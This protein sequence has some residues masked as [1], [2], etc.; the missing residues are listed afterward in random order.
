MQCYKAFIFKIM[1]KIKQKYL[2]FKTAERNFNNRKIAL[3]DEMTKEMYISAK[4][5]NIERFKTI[6][7][8]MISMLGE[9]YRFTMIQI[10]VL[11]GLNA[12]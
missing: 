3:K 8:E 6:G 1:S 7:N 10:D 4:Q 5:G 12:L 9:E 2:A 11:Y